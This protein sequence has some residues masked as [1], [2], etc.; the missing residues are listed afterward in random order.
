[1]NL[2]AAGRHRPKA[3]QLGPSNQSRPL[4]ARSGPW[5]AR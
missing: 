1:M 5:V 3:D 4:D 2:A